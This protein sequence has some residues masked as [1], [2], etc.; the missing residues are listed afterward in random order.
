MVTHTF[1]LFRSRAEMF[2][3]FPCNT[4]ITRSILAH[5]HAG[6]GTLKGQQKHF[7]AEKNPG[8]DF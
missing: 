2:P 3:V 4:C 1:L 5:N 8:A 6:T 7:I